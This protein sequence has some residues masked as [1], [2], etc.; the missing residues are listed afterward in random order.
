MVKTQPEDTPLKISHR[1]KNTGEMLINVEA[2][3]L[4][5]ISNEGAFFSYFKI[6]GVL[7][8]VPREPDRGP[9]YQTKNPGPA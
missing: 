9:F 3:A 6:R 5:S 8:L 7:M 4:K 2:V 1:L